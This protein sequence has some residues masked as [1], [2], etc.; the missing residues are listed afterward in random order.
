MYL[1][2]AFFACFIASAL[3]GG[4]VGSSGIG[5]GTGERPAWIALAVTSAAF[6]VWGLLFQ[7]KDDIFALASG[8]NVLFIPA[9]LY[10]SLAL[11][12][13]SMSLC[14]ARRREP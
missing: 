4:A 6:A 12:G 14:L 7:V 10:A 8:L 13:V 2:P 11:I 5:D 1:L 9:K 3:P